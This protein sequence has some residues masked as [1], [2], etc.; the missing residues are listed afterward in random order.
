[1]VYGQ[2][3]HLPIKS[4]DTQILDIETLV[5]R[6]IN[7]IENLLQVCNKLVACVQQAQTKMKE[8]Y[9]KKFQHNP[10]LEISN[11]FLVYQVSI[12]YNKSVK[13]EQKWK[14]AFYIHEVLPN[15]IYKLQTI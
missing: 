13:L 6:T 1:M 15:N 3:A 8:W 11:K 2:K 4:D 14:W 12:E 9:D 5:Q 10:K 7:L